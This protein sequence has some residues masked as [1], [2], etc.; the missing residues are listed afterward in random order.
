VADKDRYGFDYKGT[1]PLDFETFPEKLD[2]FEKGKV[3]NIY[4]GSYEADG[5][6]LLMPGMMEGSALTQDKIYD[7]MMEGKHFGVYDTKEDLDRADELIHEWFK[8][9]KGGKVRMTT[10]DKIM[11]F[12]KDL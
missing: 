8:R 10:E 6:H 11:D 3:S 1:L 12:I 4:T 9:L 2:I 7:L 5:K